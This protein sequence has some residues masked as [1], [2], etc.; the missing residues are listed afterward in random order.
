MPEA[1]SLENED[2]LNLIYQFSMN[3]SQEIFKRAYNET[4]KN[5]SEKVTPDILREL[6][7]SEDDIYKEFINKKD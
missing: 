6:G 7:Y 3:Y 1:K 2:F 5:I 4:Q